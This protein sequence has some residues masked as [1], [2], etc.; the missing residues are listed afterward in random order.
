MLPGKVEKF[1]AE[2]KT[3]SSI[4][5]SWKK[6]ELGGPVHGYTIMYWDKPESMI[7]V[8]VGEDVRLK[9]DSLNRLLI[10]E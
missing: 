1:D 3:P 9:N 10:F 8:S 6:P 5:M 2:L 7:E 4:L